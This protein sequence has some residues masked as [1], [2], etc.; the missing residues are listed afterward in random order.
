MYIHEN[1]FYGIKQT[2]FWWSNSFFSFVSFSHFVVESC[3]TLYIESRKCFFSR[4]FTADSV[5]EF[6]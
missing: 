2:A 4:S 6:I 5:R 1:I 3:H